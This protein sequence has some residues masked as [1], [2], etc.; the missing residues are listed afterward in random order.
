MA[1]QMIP[2]DPDKKD[3]QYYRYKMPALQTKVEGSGN[4]IKTVIPNIHDICLVINRPEEVLMK[5]FQFELGAQRT[6]STKDDKFFL[7]GSHPEDRMQDKLYDFIRRF[8]LCKH[9]RNP[10]TTIHLDETK[11]GA[12][13]ISMVCGACGK[14]SAFLEHR[15]KTFMIQYY[16]KHRDELKS[17]KHTAEARKK[18]E[19]PSA[20]DAAA[21]ATGKKETESK[22]VSKSD[23]ADDREDPKAVFARV[24]KESWG[25]NDELV[26]YTVRLLSQYNLPEHYGPPMVLSGMQIEHRDDLLST[27]R[28][29][30]RLLKRLCTVPELFSRSE[31]Y[32]EK[33]LTDFYK[34]EKKIQK[35]FLRECAKEF[36]ANYT[37]EKFAVLLFMLFVEGV[38]RD[39]SIIDWAK[40][41]KPLS[42]VDPKIQKDMHA[43]VAP[44]VAW[45]GRE[46]N[47]DA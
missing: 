31:G 25:K 41:E 30:A 14:R 7:M 45:L 18:G 21:T 33:E 5:Y 10:E 24:L 44:I 42:D 4:G 20:D 39:Q 15:T 16:D 37:A 27:M 46:T 26:G 12:P 2:V 17:A 22:T 8:V 35:T 43:K 23:L 6:V 40:D 29:H 9:C 13:E 1:T 32:D 36:A 34:R 11:K 47:A 19:Q 3:D 38:L 28:I